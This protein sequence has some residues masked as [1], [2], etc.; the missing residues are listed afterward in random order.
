M[1]KKVVLFDLDGTT[2]DTLTDLNAVMN[3]AL[4][5]FGC[6]PVT[7]EQTRSFVGKGGKQYA[8]QAL[9]DDRKKDIDEFMRIYSGL[10]AAWENGETKYFPGEDA[11]LRSLKAA[12]MR[13]GI[14]TNKSQAATESLMRTHL[15]PY[16]FEFVFANTGDEHLLKPDPFGTLQALSFFGVGPEEAV[17][18]GDGETDVRTAA[19]AGTECIAVLWGHRSREQLEK[20]GA[21]VF[22]RSFEELGRILLKTE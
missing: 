19:S 10:H 8:L 12:G 21:T 5:R 15:A 13:L 22:A 4:K 16:G 1:R 6:P 14:V 20:A 3:E 17:F 18:V 9:P 7:M 2:L 11:C